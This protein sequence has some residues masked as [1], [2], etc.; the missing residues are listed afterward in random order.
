MGGF[1]GLPDACALLPPDLPVV[2]VAPPL[3]L[4]L[5]A[6]GVVLMVA[7]VVSCCGRVSLSLLAVS[8]ASASFAASSSLPT[9]EMITAVCNHV[10]QSQSHNMIKSVHDVCV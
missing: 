3:L 1:W 6:L 2:A 4:L 7:V 5:L 8:A 10:N 9:C